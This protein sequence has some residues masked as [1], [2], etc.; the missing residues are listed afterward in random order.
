[1][2][3]V[4]LL[5]CFSVLIFAKAYATNKDSLLY[6]RYTDSLLKYEN[7]NQELAVYYIEKI[8]KLNAKNADPEKVIAFTT[9]LTDYYYS[10]GQPD[11]ALFISLRALRIAKNSGDKELVGIAYANLA[12][13][14][15]NSGDNR[16]EVRY[17][18]ESLKY[19][20]FNLKSENIGNRFFNLSLAYNDLDMPDSSRYF[21]ERAFHI[22]LDIN[23]HSGLASCYGVFAQF[24]TNE[25]KFKEAEGFYLKQISL[26]KRAN[27]PERLIIPYENTGIHYIKT[28]DFGKAKI[29]IDSAFALANSCHSFEDIYNI[30]H[31]YGE[32][33]R[34][35]GNY[36]EAY[37]YLTKYYTIRDSLF[38]SDYKTQLKSI[39]QLLEK[40][41][42]N[43]E[44]KVQK[45]ESE[46]LQKSKFYVQVILVIAVI[47]FLLII[48][49]LF[50][51]QRAKQ[52]AF[53]QL[54]L[55]KN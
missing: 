2:P 55:L 19:T 23:S 9:A 34:E 52:K 5:I 24:A 39:T 28:K 50:F 27:E 38:D 32:Y 26:F 11:S 25:N 3:K 7:S 48:G 33:H 1:M 43:L 49:F 21:L 31:T 20:P 4:I 45:L 40:E 36:K 54:M 10:L 46:N 42:S 35:T 22:F 15:G 30:Y 44:I 41:K 12:G 18:K 8:K 37:D 14:Y 13:I 51:R 47:G 16:N 29:Y 6:S 53:N 17:Y